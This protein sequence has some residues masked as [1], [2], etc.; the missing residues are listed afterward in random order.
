M[1]DLGSLGS[2]WISMKEIFKRAP[3]R[4]ALADLSPQLGGG[5]I[6][7]KGVVHAT[8]YMSSRVSECVYLW[9]LPLVF[10]GIPV[11]VLRWPH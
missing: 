3:G 10:I 7:L 8:Q 11:V 1:F 9:G 2:A 5:G 4:N 6:R